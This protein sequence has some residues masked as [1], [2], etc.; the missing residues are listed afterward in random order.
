MATLAGAEVLGL[1]RTVGSLEEGKSADFLV[2][3]VER[4]AG[5]AQQQEQEAEEV[6]AALVFS[7]ATTVLRTFVRGKQIFRAP[8]ARGG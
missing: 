2:V 7:G 1:E 8:T 4:V 5:R 6:L 3:Q